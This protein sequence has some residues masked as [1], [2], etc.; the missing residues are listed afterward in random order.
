MYRKILLLLLSLTMV[1]C[2]TVNTVFRD[3]YVV[4]VNMKDA[5]TKCSSIPRVYSGFSYDFCLL[6][7]EPYSASS[8][9]QALTPF[10]LVDIVLSGVADTVLL[11]YGIYKQVDD[12]NIQLNR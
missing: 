5:K 12:G 4:K 9:I 3:D 11:P 10:V 2:G 1:G 8:G 6:N 7:A